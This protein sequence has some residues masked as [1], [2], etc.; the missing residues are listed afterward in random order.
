M[1]LAWCMGNS[2]G[3]AD[4]LIQF[5]QHN[6]LG[7][8]SG[9]LSNPQREFRSGNHAYEAKAFVERIRDR[10]QPVYENAA[11]LIEQALNE[12]AALAVEAALRQYVERGLS[13]VLKKAKER[14]QKD[15]KITPE[16]PKHELNIRCPNTSITWSQH[17]QIKLIF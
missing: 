14:L 1:G 2:N 8:R 12:A 6:K 7:R 11:G 9:L 5:L 10:L 17:C 13:A 3:E 15:F 16:F 4:L